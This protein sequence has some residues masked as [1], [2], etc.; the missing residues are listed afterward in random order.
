MINRG[1]VISFLEMFTQ[2]GTNLQ[3]GMSF[4][5]RDDRIVFLISLRPNA[6]YAD[7]IEEDGAVLIY[8]GHDISARR[9]GPDPKMVDQPMYN[10]SA[11]LTQNGL[12][13]EAAMDYRSGFRPTRTSQS[14][15]EALTR[16]LGL[17]RD[18]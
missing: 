11:S 14:L 9:G 8:E 5:L 3:R 17:Q 15:R 10:P 2:E 4:R 18:I 13:Y 7:H 1:D 6:P 16:N 12:F